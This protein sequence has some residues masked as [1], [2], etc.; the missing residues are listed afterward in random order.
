MN[1]TK[2]EDALGKGIGYGK[3]ILFGEMFAIFGIPVIASAL[4]ITADA[5]VNPTASGGWDIQDERREAKGYKAEKKAM[6]LES[7]ERIFRHLRFRPEN[8]RIRLSGELPAMSGIGATGASSVAI[9]RALCEEFHLPLSEDEVN[10]CAYQAEIAYH[11]PTTSGVDN[12]VSTYGGIIHLTRGEPNVVQKMKWKEPV[13]VV[14]GDTGIIANTKTLLAALGERK[15]K[16]PEKYDRILRGAR[17]IAEE[18]TPSMEKFDLRGIGA[19]MNRN[20]ALLQEAEVSCPELDLLVDLCRKAGAMGAKLTGSGGGGCMLAL[21]PGRDL[22]E[23][24]ASAIESRGFQAL[25]SK[26]GVF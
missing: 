11:G 23:K 20:Q 13:E 9:V 26:L 16:A 12:M 8:L 10:A 4:S 22:Q 18:A 14:I 19:L 21:T 2:T 17:Q 6:Q 15:K 25:R 24:V 1:F 7:L 3:T 5:E